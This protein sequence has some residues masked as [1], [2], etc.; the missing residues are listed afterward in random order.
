M[1]KD[2]S[3]SLFVGRSDVR[4]KP[5]R[6]TIVPMIHHV[7]NGATWDQAA[8]AG[9]YEPASLATHGFVHCATAAQ[10]D[11]V[12]AAFYADV[13][14][15]VVLDL[16]EAVLVVRWEPP[17]HPDG[18]PARP[19]EPL[20]P[21]VYGPID[22]RAVIAARPYVRRSTDSARSDSPPTGPSG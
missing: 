21:H 2:A 20:F 16:D 22:V 14:D 15:L 9:R 11:G 6:A 19:G 7:V 13:A 1:T 12:V 4:V 3:T 5:A 17:A 8:T 18:T 10:V